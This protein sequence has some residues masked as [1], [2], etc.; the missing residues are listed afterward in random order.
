M[1]Y[2]ILYIVNKLDMRVC[3][4]CPDVQGIKERDEMI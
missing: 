2:Y 3:R 4:R 1:I